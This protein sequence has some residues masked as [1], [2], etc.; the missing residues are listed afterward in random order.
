MAHDGRA[1]NRMSGFL[2]GGDE[3]DSNTLSLLQL[4]PDPF[5]EGGADNPELMRQQIETMQKN[6]AAIHSHLKALETAGIFAKVH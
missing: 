2:P 1:T 5:V 3:A 6:I 4:A